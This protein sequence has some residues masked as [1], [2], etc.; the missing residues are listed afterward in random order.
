MRTAC[1]RMLAAAALR[2]GTELDLLEEVAWRQTDD[3]RQ[4]ALYAAFAYVCA[5]AERARV[6]VR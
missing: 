1:H 4:Y 5:A 6:P 3:F 2:G